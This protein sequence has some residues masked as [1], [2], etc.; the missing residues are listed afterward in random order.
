MEKKKPATKRRWKSSLV[1]FLVI[2]IIG[3]VLVIDIQYY[4][5]VFFEQPTVNKVLKVEDKFELSDTLFFCD[6]FM[7][8]ERYFSVFKSD[9]S[10]VVNPEDICHRCGR[11]SEAHTTEERRRL[12][13]LLWAIDDL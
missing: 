4:Y 1:I 13:F 5:S 3:V 9:S 2:I 8:H 10:A 11:K 6:E 12:K 7:I